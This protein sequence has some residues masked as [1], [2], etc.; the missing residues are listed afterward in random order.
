MYKLPEPQGKMGYLSEQLDQ[1]CKDLKISKKKFNEAFGV[2]T[3]S[4][5]EKGRTNFYS[6][7]VERTLFLLGFK[8]FTNYPWD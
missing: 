4:I 6:V 1:I 5:D 3:V 7:D 2:N 8:Q